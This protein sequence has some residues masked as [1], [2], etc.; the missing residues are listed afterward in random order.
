MMAQLNPAYWLAVHSTIATIASAAG[1]C[2]HCIKT[3]AAYL[4]ALEDQHFK[5]VAV[6]MRRLAPLLVMILALRIVVLCTTIISH[7]R[8]QY[9][10]T[11]RST[12]T[13]LE[14]TAQKHRFSANR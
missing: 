9:Q 14:R 6:I 8:F 7:I 13:S 2:L 10:T 1:S 12:Y 11:V 4:K 5:Q 3:L